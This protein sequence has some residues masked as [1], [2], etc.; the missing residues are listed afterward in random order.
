MNL[1]TLAA[2]STAGFQL[3]FTAMLNRHMVRLT[4]L[5]VGLTSQL[6]EATMELYKQVRVMLNTDQTIHVCP[7]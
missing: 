2:I 7:D 4:S 1:I 5:S 6:V 3:I